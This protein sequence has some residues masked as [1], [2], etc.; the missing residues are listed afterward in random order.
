MSNLETLINIG[1][2]HLTCFQAE[3]LEECLIK[4]NGGLSIP[5]GYGK[6]LISIVLALIQ[7]KETNAPILVV[8][9][10]TLISSW[11][12]EINKFFGN[13][14]KYVVFHKDY[15][16]D[17][18]KL[19]ILSDTVLVLTTPETTLK[20]YNLLNIKYRF[21]ERE[22]INPGQFNQHEIVHYIIQDINIPNSNTGGQCLHNTCWSVVIIDEAQNYTKITTDRS[23]SMASISSTY[24]WC[25]S[26]TLFS[27]IST[28]RLLGY[29][30]LINNKEF[31]DNLPEADT[32]LKSLNFKGINRTIVSRD[33]TN[34]HVIPIKYNNHIITI[35]FNKYEEII[36]FFIKDI[37]LDINNQ[38]KIFKRENDTVNIRKFNAMLL[39]ML[40]YL[41]Q[42][43]V[44]PLIPISNI[45]IDLYDLTN[46]N[47]LSDIF[48]NKLKTL[49]ISEYL[50]NE[51]NI[52]S[53]RI[54]KALELIDKHDKVIVFSVYRTSLCILESFIENREVF[55]LTGTMSIKKRNEIIEKCKS[56]DRCVLLLTYNIGAEGLNLQFID[57]MVLLDFEWSNGTTEQA[58]ARIVR[59][60]T[61]SN[62]INIYY[63][64]SNTGVENAIFRKHKQKNIII[65]EIATG[66]ILSKVDKINTKEIITILKTETNVALYKSIKIDF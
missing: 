57:N 45:A 13:K 62:N 31:P 33:K 27:E 50:Y 9:S 34:E 20:Y 58:I 22:I 65:S 29:H 3:I 59:Q 7:S 23:R 30:L 11:I 14:L 66:P 15:L 40:I 32:L 8:V 60:G 17:L 12:G 26:G 5:M 35:V 56:L 36:Y 19:S 47:E 61:I 6:T 54:S 53:S 28:E 55:T 63:L 18:S 10:K 1:Y 52:K 37:L 46:K 38:I 41:R 21:L 51:E 39:A 16:K 25:L 24:K 49:N 42:C 43:L 64:L 2:S 48:N 44:S 4:Q